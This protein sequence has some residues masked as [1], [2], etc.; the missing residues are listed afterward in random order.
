MTR[1]HAS[2][3]PLCQIEEPPTFYEGMDDHPP[4]ET[5]ND[6]NDSFF[7]EDRD[8][9]TDDASLFPLT[10]KPHQHQ[11]QQQTLSKQH[12]QYKQQK[13][14]QTKTAAHDILCNH[15]HPLDYEHRC[16]NEFLQGS[17]QNDLQDQAN[18]RMQH[19]HRNH[20]FNGHNDNDQYSVIDEPNPHDYSN[21][22][23]AEAEITAAVVTTDAVTK[24]QRRRERT[25]DGSGEQIFFYDGPNLMHAK[26]YPDRFKGDTLS[27]S[28]AGT[29]IRASPGT[30]T[31]TVHSQEPLNTK[32]KTT[33]SHGNNIETNGSSSNSVHINAT[34]MP[35]TVTTAAASSKANAYGQ[36][37]ESPYDVL[38]PVLSHINTQPIRSTIDNSSN[39]AGACPR[40]RPRARTRS[41][42]RSRS[43]SGTRN[44]QTSSRS[45]SR[46]RSTS[47]AWSR[48][49]SESL[50]RKDQL[51]HQQPSSYPKTKS[52]PSILTRGFSADSKSKQDHEQQKSSGGGSQAG[53]IA[54]GNRKITA[55]ERLV[56]LVTRSNGASTPIQQ[57][58]DAHGSSTD[59]SS[60]LSGG[61]RRGSADD[62]SAI[63]AQTHHRRQGSPS[64][65]R[66]GR[67]YSTPAVSS[68]SPV[69]SASPPVDTN[70]GFPYNNSSL[71]ISSDFTKASV[72]KPN[73]L[74]SSRGQGKPRPF[75]VATME[76]LLLS[77]NQPISNRSNRPDSTRLEK[78]FSTTGTDGQE[79]SNQSADRHSTH[80]NQINCSHPH[81]QYRQSS[82]PITS[83]SKNLEQDLLRS[84][85]IGSGSYPLLAS[86]GTPTEASMAG[87]M[88]GSDRRRSLAT[89]GKGK[90]AER[91][92]ERDQ[93]F[94]LVKTT[95]SEPIDHLTSSEGTEALGAPLHLHEH[96]I[97]YHYYCQH[98]PPLSQ[99]NLDEIGE[100]EGGYSSLSSAERRQTLQHLE[101]AAS[102]VMAQP[103]RHQHGNRL[104]IA[105]EFC[106]S[107]TSFSRRG[108]M[109]MVSPSPIE[110][111]AVTTTTVNGA[112]A[113]TTS[114]KNKKKSLLGTMTMTSSMRRKFFAEH[115]QEQKQQ[116]QTQLQQQQQSFMAPR[117]A[118]NGA[119]DS[120]HHYDS[121]ISYG[122][123]R[124]QVLPIFNMGLE[125][126]DGLFRS[127]GATFRLKRNQRRRVSLA[128]LA[129]EFDEDEER[130]RLDLGHSKFY[131][132]YEYE[133]GMNGHLQQPL[134]S[135][136]QSPQQQQ[137]QRAKFLSRLKQFL[138]R[139]SPFAKNYSSTLSNSV[140]NND[141][142]NSN[143]NNIQ[144]AAL[145]SGLPNSSSSSAYVTSISQDTTSH[146]PISSHQQSTD[147]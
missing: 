64:L 70:S 59:G 58:K 16:S 102:D 123:Q 25:L 22:N 131:D 38:Q 34:T 101:G 115:N 98:C 30:A 91:L 8:R 142:C 135:N 11:H 52:R 139:P 104:E 132:D 124:H 95:Y 75:S 72:N 29:S 126:S 14:Q 54:S 35:I 12:H 127:S 110:D 6:D 87:P 134:S 18:D 42:S 33:I 116:Q 39:F 80:P 107:P 66:T 55:K 82:V 57:T 51:Y 88:S 94:K 48:T 97:H 106:T 41:R 141:S 144:A 49:M 60:P 26:L 108:F 92:N 43:R 44:S 90:E 45:R 114:K 143:D 105:T 2:L 69:N 93:R 147:N 125:K 99:S 5:D 137:Q 111:P 10:T 74:R 20:Q 71:L 120:Y 19:H 15:R 62:R 79:S 76:K 24:H 103:L 109:P 28:M 27:E 63:L 86:I 65:S 37:T 128:G 31:T 117:G 119:G 96:H 122:T 68:S 67:D 136:D 89:V 145:S 121:G 146:V 23:E 78:T 129:N 138:L 133:F 100:M 4:V 36:I 73:A 7:L 61:V 56:A 9:D 118:C 40:S 32:N 46:S 83:Q 17:D 50:A 1:Y 112:T 53:T 47:G 3:I 85:M 13:Q 21:K 84:R 81:Q 77:N 140:N 113:A 130:Q